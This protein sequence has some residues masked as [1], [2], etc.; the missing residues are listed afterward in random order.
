[1]YNIRKKEENTENNRSV[2]EYK[3]EYLLGLLKKRYLIITKGDLKNYKL[4]NVEIN[5][6]ED[7]LY[8]DY[9]LIEIE[10]NKEDDIL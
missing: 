10:E 7:V 6:E 2:Q 8:L 5:E 1:M 4:E 3:S 9:Y